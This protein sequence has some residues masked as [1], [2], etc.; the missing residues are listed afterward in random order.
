LSLLHDFIGSTL[1]VIFSSTK[2]YLSDITKVKHALGHCPENTMFTIMWV[3]HRGADKFN[4]DEGKIHKDFDEE[5]RLN[6]IS[7]LVLTQIYSKSETP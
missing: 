2:S 6:K 1:I 5:L 3:L 4:I 7:K